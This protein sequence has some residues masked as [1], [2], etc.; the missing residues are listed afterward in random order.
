MPADVSQ[1]ATSVAEEGLDIPDCNLV[2]RYRSD[3]LC[4]CWILLLIDA[5]LTCIIL[6][7]NT[8]RAADVRD[9]LIQ[10]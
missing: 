9:I 1:F 3:K 5:G 6:S 8:C 7:F 4:P 10:L 2:V